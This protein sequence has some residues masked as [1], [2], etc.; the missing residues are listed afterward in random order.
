MTATP[1]GHP[2]VAAG[3]D[4]RP[5]VELADG[6][7]GA[8]DPAYRARRDA[9]A[10]AALAWSPGRPVPRIDYTAEEDGTWAAVVAALLPRW[11][12][13]AAAS[14]LDG[15]DALDLPVDRVPQL[16]EVSARLHPLV[17]FR[18]HPVAGL[19]PLREF[20]RSFGD[21]I[22][23]STQYLRHHS[24]P[25]YTPEPDVCHEVLGHAHQL[26][27]PG[28]AAL[29]RAVAAAASRLEAEAS[30]RFVS[31]VFWHTAEFG[32]VQE[33][34][35]V[36][37]WGA[38]LLSSAGELAAWRQAEHR[39]VDLAAMGTSSYDITRFQEVLYV[40]PSPSWITEDL[41]AWLSTVDDEACARLGALPA[42]A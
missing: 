38:G 18:Y 9:T 39:P 4:G 21:G 2:V 29:Y 22:F 25:L 16:D 7:P 5:V 8:T 3:V 20:Y 36:A 15:V 6:H 31:R 41:P 34:D 19:A 35:R 11:R 42:P 17:G 27:D 10:A 33:G 24:R 12:A 1:S 40:A 23:H 37:V 30:L 26:A 28:V 13:D 32:L 14:F